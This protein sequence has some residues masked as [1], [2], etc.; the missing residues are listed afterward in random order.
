MSLEQREN[1]RRHS[2]HGR[3]NGW[4]E[5]VSDRIPRWCSVGNVS[6]CDRYQFELRSVDRCDRDWSRYCTN[7]HCID[8]CSRIQSDARRSNWQNIW[9]WMGWN[10]LFLSISRTA[11][12]HCPRSH[13][14]CPP[15]Q[16]NDDGRTCH[17]LNESI[18][19]ERP[20]SRA[21]YENTCAHDQAEQ[22]CHN[23]RR[24]PVSARTIGVRSDGQRRFSAN[25][26]SMSMLEEKHCLHQDTFSLCMDQRIDCSI[27]DG[28]RNGIVGTGSLERRIPCKKMCRGQRRHSRRTKACPNRRNRTWVIWRF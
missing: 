1:S 21:T 12:E 16:Y 9:I 28:Q 11:R 10:L 6:K 15:S 25:A 5:T 27:L 23:D 8:S 7:L 22:S 26:E 20:S 18:E 3:G 2:C 19:E 13:N 14:S 17:N 24:R 4:I